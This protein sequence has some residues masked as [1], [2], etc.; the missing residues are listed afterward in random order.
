MPLILISF[1]I[2]E[3]VTNFLIWHTCPKYTNWTFLKKQNAKI[4]KYNYPLLLIQKHISVFQ[5]INMFSFEG[6]TWEEF[7]MDLFLY[8]ILGLFSNETWTRHHLNIICLPRK[9]FLDLELSGNEKFAVFVL[10]TEYAKPVWTDFHVI[11]IQKII[12][13]HYRETYHLN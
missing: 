8:M 6:K 3:T 4:I 9:Q 10:L 2:Q 11:I 7:R 5:F 1:L 13:S 12:C